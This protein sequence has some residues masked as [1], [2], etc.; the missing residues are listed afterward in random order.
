MHAYGGVNVTIR[1]VFFDLMGTLARFVPEQEDLLV[2]AAA[3]KGVS[4]SPQAAR[5]GFAVTGDWWNQQL[6]RLPIA[7]RSR[8][9]KE[10]LYR[11][12]DQHVLQ[13]AGVDV[14]EELA[15]QIFGELLRTGR[16]SHLARFDDVLPALRALRE[17]G[18]TLGVI[19]NMGREL[20][21]L[22]EALEVGSY[23]TAT[24]SAAE[25]G[26]G[27]PDPRI[28]RAALEKAGVP[29]HEAL[30]VGDQ[31]ENDVVGARQ[32]GMFPALVDRYD[33]FPQHTD[34]LRV[35]SLEEL[36]AYVAGA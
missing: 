7:A 27:K 4:L 24:V 36:A 12:F 9:A 11:G 3:T 30:H 29:Q 28:F 15:F 1:A 5:R 25:A 6:S 19:S 20:S 8:P 10:A 32:A 22:L 13:A 34:C 35:R 23:F 2:A 31:Y 33:L 26:A 18:V 21:Q 16:G 14:S 17:Q